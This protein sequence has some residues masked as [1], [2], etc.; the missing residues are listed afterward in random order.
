MKYILLLTLFLM[1]CAIDM[2][3]KDYHFAQLNFRTN[4]KVTDKKIAIFG[5]SRMDYMSS[6]QMQNINYQCWNFGRT[7]S[8]S[9][10]ALDDMTIIKKGEFYDINEFIIIVYV[11]RNDIILSEGIA[12]YTQDIQAMQIL[13]PNNTFY[14]IN[15][16][17]DSTL[18]EYSESQYNLLSGC[19]DYNKALKNLNVN[20][21]NLN[22]YICDQ[23]G[24]LKDNLTIDHIHF[25]D[26]GFRYLYNFINNL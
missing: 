22:Q 26:N 15:C 24:Y 5:D 8:T 14:F 12:R 13:Y 6:S 9:I 19:N 18:S 16:T 3:T 25:N 21:V 2:P 4:N 7:H 23:A 20:Y 17:P 11:G 10:E 1:S